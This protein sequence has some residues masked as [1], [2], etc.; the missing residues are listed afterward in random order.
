MCWSFKCILGKQKTFRKTTSCA[1]FSEN[2]IPTDTNDARTN[3]A[4]PEN[5]KNSTSYMKAKEKVLLPVEFN[6]NKDAKY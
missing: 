1:L 5:N 4:L 6:A 3:G 2:K